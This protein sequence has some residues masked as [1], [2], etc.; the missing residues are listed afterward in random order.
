MT[1]KDPAATISCNGQRQ[2]GVLALTLPVGQTDTLTVTV[3]NGEAA[4][5]YTIH[6]KGG[7][8]PGAKTGKS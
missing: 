3:P 5:T 7:H 6:L 1:A 4:E 2:E 8:R